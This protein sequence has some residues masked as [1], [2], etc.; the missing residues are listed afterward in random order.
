M[1]LETEDKATIE[2]I[3]NRAV[4]QINFA[5]FN[6]AKVNFELKVQAVCKETTHTGIY[7]ALW[8]LILMVEPD[9]FPI[10][11]SE[12]IMVAINLLFFVI[13]E[14]DFCIYTNTFD[15]APTF[16]EICFSLFFSS[17]F[18]GFHRKIE[19]IMSPTA[20]LNFPCFF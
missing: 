12:K 7:S 20:F 16:L 6:H 5:Y 19:I 18:S 2:R 1:L 10:L 3:S 13:L 11:D 4:V 14:L 15:P 9:I 17:I 8:F